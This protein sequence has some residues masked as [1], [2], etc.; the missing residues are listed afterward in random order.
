MRKLVLVITDKNT[1]VDE[2]LRPF[3]INQKIKNK[4]VL[5]NK[6]TLIYKEKEKIH[7]NIHDLEKMLIS[8]IVPNNRRAEIKKYINKNRKIL[9]KDD[10]KIYKLAIKDYPDYLISP[11]GGIYNNYNPYAKWY[12]YNKESDYAKLF[13]IENPSKPGEFINVNSAKI[14]DIKWDKIK[15]GGINTD[16]TVL[17]DGNWYNEKE[18]IVTI[19]KKDEH[20]EYELKTEE[21][22]ELYRKHD[23]NETAT[24]V[25][26]FN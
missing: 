9:E 3:G 1:T 16:A 2:L 22:K 10:D 14:K 18:G 20:N 7:D 13:V 24:I 4:E 19:V 6:Q 15:Y 17:P 8:N 11:E 26:F 23:E 5:Y 25:E 21:I 12:Y